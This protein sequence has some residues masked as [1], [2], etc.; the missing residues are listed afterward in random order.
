MKKSK[1]WMICVFIVIFIIAAFVMLQG[2]RE[3]K[4]KD[5]TLVL[6]RIWLNDGLYQSRGQCM[7]K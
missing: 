5:G 6:E 2:R 3:E 7:S 1:Q 4:L